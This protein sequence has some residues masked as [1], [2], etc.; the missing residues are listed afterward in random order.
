MFPPPTPRLED[1]EVDDDVAA[2]VWLEPWDD[3]VIVMSVEG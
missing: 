2:E 3:D 1:E